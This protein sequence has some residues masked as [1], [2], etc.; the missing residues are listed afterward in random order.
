MKEGRKEGKQERTG[1]RTK[2]EGR[3]IGK[4]ELLQGEGQRGKE[5]SKREIGGEKR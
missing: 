5:K 4:E 2:R 1:G 3:Q